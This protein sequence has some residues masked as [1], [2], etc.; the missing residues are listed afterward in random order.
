[1][2][3]DTTQ[4]KQYIEAHIGAI[5]GREDVAK[6]FDMSIEQL[7]KAFLKAEGVTPTEFIAE[8]RVEAAKWLLRKG[9]LTNKQVCYAVGYAR[10]DSGERAFKEATGQ[11]MQAFGKQHQRRRRGARGG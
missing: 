2:T 3:V 7:R 5:R 4:I 6:H 1:M 9:G 11:A 10:V 8:A